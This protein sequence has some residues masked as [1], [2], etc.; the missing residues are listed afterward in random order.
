MVPLEPLSNN[1]QVVMNL[2][3]YLTIRFHR[4]HMEKYCFLLG[5]L[6]YGHILHCSSWFSSAGLLAIS[7]IYRR[8]WFPLAGLAVPIGLSS[9]SPWGLWRSLWCRLSLP[10][11]RNLLDSHLHAS[12]YD[13][14]VS[15][16]HGIT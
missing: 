6:C 15:Y 14:N 12:I 9:V 8:F 11:G 1:P 2:I 3:F 10:P 16:K 13:V 7:L 5:R 4:Y